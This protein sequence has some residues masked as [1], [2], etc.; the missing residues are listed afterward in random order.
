MIDLLTAT[1]Y[2]IIQGVTEFLPISFKS[3]LAEQDY[4]ICLDGEDISEKIRTEAI[5][6]LSSKVASIP[7]VRSALLALQRSFG[8]TEGLVTDGRDMGTV[9]FPDARLKIYLTADATVRAQR[10]YQQLIGKGNDVTIAAVQQELE[11]RDQR[12]RQRKA[13]PLKPADDLI[14]HSMRS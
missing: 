6:Q 1:I 5:S 8:G 2:G 12:D 10:R 9:V 14:H 4:T 7:D 11:A 13:S 3:N